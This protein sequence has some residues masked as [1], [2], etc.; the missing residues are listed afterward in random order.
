MQ[1]TKKQKP[2]NL[3]SQMKVQESLPLHLSKKK[4]RMT[5]HVQKN[6]N[7]KQ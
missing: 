2:Y 3:E 5:Y 4:L 6:A 7:N 1:I